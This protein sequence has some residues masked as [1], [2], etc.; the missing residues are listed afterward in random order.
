[1][2]LLPTHGALRTC[3]HSRHHLL[4]WLCHI[5][6]HQ[7]SLLSPPISFL[8]MFFL[9][10]TTRYSSERRIT[11]KGL[12]RFKIIYQDGAKW[13][14]ILINPIGHSEILEK[15]GVEA[16]T[17]VEDH[18]NCMSTW[19]KCLLPTH[20]CARMMLQ[21]NLIDKSIHVYSLSYCF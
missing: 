16:L 21:I 18:C 19:Y 3:P 10:L 11:H 8:K 15:M 17:S 14:T 1:M 7:A 5:L 2:A 9:R 6:K 12:C 13:Y 20:A 4:Q